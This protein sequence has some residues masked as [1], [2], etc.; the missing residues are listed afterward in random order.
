[1]PTVLTTEDFGKSVTVA[2]G[3]MLVLRLPENPTTGYAWHLA[4][5]PAQGIEIVKEGYAGVPAGGH[6]REGLAGGGAVHEFQLHAS[7][8]G[9][10]V[11]LLRK[12]FGDDW[13]PDD[14]K[15]QMRVVVQP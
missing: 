12:S 1:M 4:T 9:T 14:R 8:P 7:R 11:V 13:E 6:R 5:E 3:E 15:E 2:P 10:F